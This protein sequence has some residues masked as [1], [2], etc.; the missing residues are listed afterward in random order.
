MKFSWKTTVGGIIA[1]LSGVG[2]MAQSDWMP[3][4]QAIGLISGGIAL[5]FGKDHDV[6]GGKRKQ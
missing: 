2:D 5:L 6:S 3:G 1:I 4:P